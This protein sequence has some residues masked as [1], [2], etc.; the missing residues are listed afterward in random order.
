MTATDTLNAKEKNDK[1]KK[2]ILASNQSKMY[3]KLLKEAR[4]IES[5]AYEYK[6]SAEISK[7]K[8]EKNR[9]SLDN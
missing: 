5:M 3:K 4:E 2:D 7:F 9:K 6:A 8:K 1:I